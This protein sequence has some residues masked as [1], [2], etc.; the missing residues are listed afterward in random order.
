M[1]YVE[2][3]TAPGKPSNVR[4]LKKSVLFSTVV[5]CRLRQYA[6][7]IPDN[8]A[9]PVQMWFTRKFYVVPSITGKK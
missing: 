7:P 2:Q 1:A 9:N 5:V 4:K 6:F 8:S 3:N